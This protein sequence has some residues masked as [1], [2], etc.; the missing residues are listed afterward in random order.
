MKGNK[1]GGRKKG[2][3]NKLNKEVRDLLGALVKQELT[4]LKSYIKTLDKKD[5]AQ[6]LTKLLPFTVAPPLP[7]YEDETG[8]T[9]YFA[10]FG[11]TIKPEDMVRTFVI[12]TTPAL[13]KNLETL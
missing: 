8:E 6:I 7:T 11:Q 2:T 5:R 12:N 9:T 10:D 13:K 1:T 4:E 3:P